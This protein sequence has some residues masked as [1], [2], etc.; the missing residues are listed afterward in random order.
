MADKD[1]SFGFLSAR[2][3]DLTGQPHGIPIEVYTRVSSYDLRDLV[4]ITV[5]EQLLYDRRTGDTAG[6]TRLRT[7]THVIRIRIG[8]YTVRQVAV[9][10]QTLL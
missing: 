7:V 8:R 2:Q 10:R 3:H 5:L 9:R 1:E 4:L 6:L